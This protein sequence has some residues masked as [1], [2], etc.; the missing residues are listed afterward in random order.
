MGDVAKMTNAAVP[1]PVAGE[2]A[3]SLDFAEFF[4]GEHTRLLWAL[5]LLTGNAR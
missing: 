2:R 5:Y 1:P 4:E 3:D